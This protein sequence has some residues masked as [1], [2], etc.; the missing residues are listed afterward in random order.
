M[1]IGSVFNVADFFTYR[2]TF[3]PP[4]LHSVSADMSFT[5]VSLAL[6]IALEPAYEILD[7]LD[8]FITPHSGGYRLFFVRWKD[9]PSIDH[10]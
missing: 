6:S 3:K 5:P 8:E 10:A 4:V 7:I 1:S 2:G 9:C